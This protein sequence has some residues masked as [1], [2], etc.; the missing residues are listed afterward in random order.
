ME[1]E[2]GHLRVPLGV[3]NHHEQNNSGRKRFMTSISQVTVNPSRK[4]K[5]ETQTGQEPEV[6]S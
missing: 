1:S 3:M 5:A 6:R 4:A 2:D